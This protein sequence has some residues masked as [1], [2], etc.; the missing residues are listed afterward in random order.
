MSVVRRHTRRNVLSGAG[1]EEIK[2]FV[3]ASQS[4]GRRRRR[5]S[6]KV[7]RS[8]KSRKSRRTRRRRRN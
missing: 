6:R 8:R 3:N 4:G 1:G 5:K 2:N 7:R